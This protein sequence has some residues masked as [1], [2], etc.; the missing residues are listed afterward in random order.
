MTPEEAAVYANNFPSWH[1][2]PEDRVRFLVLVASHQTRVQEAKADLER[3]EENHMRL[4]HET[5]RAL[6]RNTP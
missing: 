4:S 6:E 3:D 5:N 1:W 2:E